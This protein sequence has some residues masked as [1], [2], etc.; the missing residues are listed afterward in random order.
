MKLE[1]YIII[2][3][4][5]RD[6]LKTILND[7]L[8]M[9][10][11]R[12]KSKMVFE[13]A[14]IKS[15]IFILEINK[16]INDTYFFFLVNYLAYPIGFK[17]TFEVEGYTIA[18][19]HKTLLNKKIYV[20]NNLE[21]TEYD[22]VWITTEEN[23]TYKFDFDG[24]L[25]KTDLDKKYKALDISDSLVIYE[26]IIINKK[27][28]LDE[29]KRR[30]DEKSNRSLKKRFKIIS[31]AL[32]ISMPLAFLLAIITP[33]FWL[34]IWTVLSPVIIMGWFIMDY[35]IFSNIKRTSICVL[36]SLINIALGISIQDTFIATVTTIPLSSVVVMWTANKFLGTKL[37]YFNDK[38]DRL[39][40]GV[41]SIIASLIS[42]LVFN[43]I[44]KL[45]K[46]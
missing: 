24:K 43:P 41:A 16:S 45:L 31:I 26:Q 38:W 36:L 10:V 25:K 20:F 4:C 29:A 14:Q 40:F 8:I 35:K 23:E 2:Q 37:D 34:M 32:F 46:I 1:K 3:N 17:K 30:K 9:Y 15:H 27:E 22:N 11:D 5:T 28:L 39:F 33:M 7:W 42:G 44:L 21:D 6:E 19:K 13:I 12:L 18:A